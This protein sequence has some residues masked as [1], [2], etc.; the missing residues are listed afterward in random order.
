[1]RRFVLVASRSGDL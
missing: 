1:M